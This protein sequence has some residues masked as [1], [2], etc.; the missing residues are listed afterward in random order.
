VSTAVYF[1]LETGGTSPA[2]P[3]I[4]LAAI[5]VDEQTGAELEAF[6]VK[7]AFDDAKADPAALE[8]NHYDRT[9]WNRDAV[10]PWLA[11]GRFVA[12]LERYRSLT[13]VSQ[14]TGRPYTVAKLVGHNAAT[15]DGPRLKALFEKHGRF[16]PA[17]MRVRCTCQRALWYF[18]EQGLAPPEN[19]RLGTLC[20]YFGILTPPTHDALDDVRATI[21]LAR[22][23]AAAAK[24]A[25]CPA[26]E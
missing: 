23:I 18:D 15:F 25:P 13:L 2:H 3:D 24:G 7:L 1:D 12:F 19:F 17:D 21:A 8:L 26:T 20:R 9:V 22:A 11:V 16:L 6:E 4:Q 5:A 14:R 10:E